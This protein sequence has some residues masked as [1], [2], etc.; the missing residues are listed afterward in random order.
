M[1]FFRGRGGGGT[2]GEDTQATPV[3]VLSSTKRQSNVMNSSLTR[4]LTTINKLR[5]FSYV[6]DKL[7]IESCMCDIHYVNVI[8]NKHS[9]SSF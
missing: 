9:Q 7:I 3:T 6:P 8:E 4:S 5:R 1:S 2:S